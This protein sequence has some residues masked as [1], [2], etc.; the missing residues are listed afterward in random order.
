MT[1]ATC[2]APTSWTGAPGPRSASARRRRIYRW[3]Q[4]N[5]NHWEHWNTAGLRLE[6]AVNVNG[7][8]GLHNNWNLHAGSTIGSL[9]ES[10]CD[11]C[12]RG[13]PALRDSRG[14]FPWFG[15]NGDSRYKIVPS[16]WVNL[17]FDDEG[18]SSSVSLSPSLTFRFSTRMQANLGVNYSSGESNTQWFDNFTVNGITHYTFARLDQRTVSMNMRL[19]Y[20]ATPDLTVEFYGEPF[21][22][23]GTFS[24][25]RET[26]STPGAANYQDRFVPYTVP[27]DSRTGF[28]FSQLRTNTVLRWEYRP[29][30][31]LFLV[32]AHGR[33]A[34]E[35][36]NLD[37]TWQKDY[38]ELFEEHPDNTFLIKVAYWLN[39]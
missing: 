31:T 4:F 25:F 3:A 2:A 9:T 13:G 12:T 39:R 7:H 23:T 33:Q 22:T 21:V 28:N 24:D 32:W 34:S 15:V 11:R 35:N 8:L 5:A 26:S 37:R 36:R 16:M 14:I 27:A 20:T 30:S 19:N 29:G 17:S 1:W 18:R 6:N 38:R 10:Y